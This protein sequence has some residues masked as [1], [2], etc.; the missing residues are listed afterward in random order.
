MSVVV[1]VVDIAVVL[2]E[3]FDPLLVEVAEAVVV[4]AA[5][6]SPVTVSNHLLCASSV[7]TFLLLACRAMLQICDRATNSRRGGYL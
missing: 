2:N 5:V 4:A 3:T 7:A 1:A 6:I